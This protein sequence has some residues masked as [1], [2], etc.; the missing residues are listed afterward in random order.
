VSLIAP[1]AMLVIAALDFAE[2]ADP[3]G[4]PPAD[5][6][7]RINLLLPA[8]EVI[9]WMAVVLLGLTGLRRAAAAIALVPFVL[10]VA[11]IPQLAVGLSPAWF[12]GLDFWSPI[13]MTSL[14]V[15]SLAFSAGPRR[16]VAIA[17]RGRA[18]V[19]TGPSPSATG[20]R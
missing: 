1:A 19:M 15:C 12:G 2:A 17:G 4:P 13:A 10:A 9:L 20:S 5:L 16:G 3:A 11:A 18:L 8:T 7:P 14:V 6:V